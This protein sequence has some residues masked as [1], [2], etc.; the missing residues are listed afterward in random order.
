[1]SQL[2]PFV[3]AFRALAK[4]AKAEAEEKRSR[5]LAIAPRKEDYRHADYVAAVV[6]DGFWTLF[7]NAA[8]DLEQQIARDLARTGPLD[9]TQA[10]TGASD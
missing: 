6:F 7:E 9:V 2:T 5:S 4:F 8:T 1:M 3:R 10:E